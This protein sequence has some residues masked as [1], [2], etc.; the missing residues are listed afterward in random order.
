MQVTNTIV[1]AGVESAHP[2]YATVEKLSGN[3]LLVANFLRPKAQNFLQR[4]LPFGGNLRGRI[5]ILSTH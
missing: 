3:L 2:N 5:K 1:V 4:N